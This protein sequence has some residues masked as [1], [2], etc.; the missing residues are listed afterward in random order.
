MKLQNAKT[1]PQVLYG[2][3]M[4][5]GCAEYRDGEKP[6]RIYIGEDAIKKMDQT[7]TGRPVYVGHV[8][9]VN[10]D[11]LQN[12]ADGY[13]VESFFNK[14]DGKHWCKFIVVSDKGQEALKKGW[15]LSNAYKIKNTALGGMWH[16]MDYDKEVIEG[17]YEHLAIVPDPRYDESIILTSEQFKDYNSKKEAELIKLANS[18]ETK[19]EKSSMF[20]F[21]KK[22]KVANSA[23]IEGMSV[24]LPKSGKEVTLTT[25]IN[26]ADEKAANEDKPKYAVEH[27]LVKLNDKDM[28]VAELVNM[29][30]NLL[31]E[32]AKNAAPE[33][34]EEMKPENKEDKAE[35]KKE[36]KDA[37]PEAK[38]VKENKEDPEKIAEKKENEEDKGDEEGKENKKKNEEDEEKKKN[39]LANF[40]KL[41]NAHSVT[42]ERTV[43]VM[44]DQVARG[45]SRYGSN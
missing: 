2:L 39:A 41:K 19:K 13:V 32:K 6:Y 5:E 23:D 45:K 11:N 24:T 37:A 21:F 28:T 8:D 42:P 36:N 43:E 29:C 12:E 3:H 7:F 17:E 15:K 22:E 20:N 26:E 27:E 25:I 34:K 16:G 44:A 35:E 4:S 18:K 33:K 10:M 40:D 30:K 31:E 14:A 1:L 38:E 9:D